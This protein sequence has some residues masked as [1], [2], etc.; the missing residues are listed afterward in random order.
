MSLSNWG[1]YP[2]VAT[3][4]IPCLSTKHIQDIVTSQGGVIG[5]GLGRCYG[6]SA[7]A[8]VILSTLPL[9][10]VINFNKETGVI[11]CEAGVSFS[12]LLP[13]IV[14][15]G[16]FL[17]VTPGTQFITVGGAVAANVHGKNHHNVGAFCDFVT[18]IELISV[19]GNPINC[20]PKST[21][22]DM[23]CGGM[24]LTGLITKVTFQLIPI[25]TPYIKQK[26]L[27]LNTIEATM[28]AFDQHQS[29]SYS[30]AW[31]DCLSTGTHFGRSVLLLGEHATK[32]QCHEAAINPTQPYRSLSFSV[33]FT[34]PLLG[35][36]LNKLLNAGYYAR[37]RETE[38]IVHY[39]P[40]FYP[41]DTVQNWN[42]LYGSKGLVQYQCVFPLSSSNT[43]LVSLLKM[44]QQHTVGSFLCVLKKMGPS[45][46]TG[47]SFPMEG[48]T[49]T[50]DFPVNQ[51]TLALCDT[52][53]TV[54]LD[55][56]G[57]HYLA[58]DSRLSKETFWKS[59]GD[60]A[61]SFQSF[62]QSNEL[63][64]TFQSHQSRRLDL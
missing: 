8:D 11:T 35:T 59:Y 49:I 9:N 56:G 44:V 52:M 2:S 41:L 31:L 21:Y 61:K 28:E 20:K 51:K 1:R 40:Y 7:L 12:S 32:E 4:E 55:H 14:T 43:G 17:P 19:G 57:R 13:K 26:T 37:S 22:F 53:D 50:F 23:T 38:A 47:L 25:E 18:E 39:Q 36:K 5:R 27:K 15:A 6:D 54:V 64:E 62:R 30:V 24:G 3:E 46:Q 29:A 10:R 34:V 45:N 16:W 42:R 58:K 48:F 33:P 63:V 60:N